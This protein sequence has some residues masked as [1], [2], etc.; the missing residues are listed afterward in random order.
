MLDP[1]KLTGFEAGADWRSRHLSFSATGY[2]NRI[3]GAIVN[4]MCELL[5]GGGSVENLDAAAR[6][7]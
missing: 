5:D 1:E 6:G 2:W 7:G 4:E 3:S